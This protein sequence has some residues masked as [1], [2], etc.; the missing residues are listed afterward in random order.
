ML[1]S[2]LLLGEGCTTQKQEDVSVKHTIGTDGFM[3]GDGR[4][5]Q[6]YGVQAAFVPKEISPDYVSN[7]H[8]FF[9]N[10]LEGK[11]VRI[12]IRSSY[13]QEY[14]GNKS[15]P[16]YRAIVYLPDGRM[17]NK[18]MLSAGYYSVKSQDFD[19][20]DQ[21]LLQEFQDLQR[22]AKAAHKGAWA[23]DHDKQ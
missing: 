23:F 9:A 18:E 6:L 1:L 19:K 4:L 7:L 3:T 13:I 11:T 12:E 16:I 8:V 17:L 20:K 21:K 10:H 14:D 5:V 15:S 22:A 2:L